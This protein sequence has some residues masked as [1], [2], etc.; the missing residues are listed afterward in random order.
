MIKILHGLCLP[1]CKT[2]AWLKTQHLP[3]VFKGMR[4]GNFKRS[5]ECLEKKILAQTAEITTK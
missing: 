2:R 4:K 5:F 1:T 3:W